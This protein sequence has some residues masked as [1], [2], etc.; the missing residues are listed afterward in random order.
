MGL[1]TLFDFNGVLIDDEALHLAAFAA[2][3]SPLSVDFAEEDYWERYIGYDDVGAFR[4]I[5]ADAGRSAPQELVLEL[6]ARKKPLYMELARDGLRA[7]PGA[8]ELVAARSQ[9]GAVGVVS[10]ALRDEIELGLSHLGVRQHVQHIVS[11]EDTHACKPDPEGYRLALE[12]FRRSDPAVQA[13]AIEDSVAGVTAARTAGLRCIGVAHSTRAEELSKA[14]AAV[15]R[16]H[17]RDVSS[18]DFA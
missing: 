13:V 16:E 17:L 12:Y 8:A 4:A 7:F 11:A 1:L 18:S 3:L 14:G 2:A 15:V 9:A 5:L 6:V 10:G